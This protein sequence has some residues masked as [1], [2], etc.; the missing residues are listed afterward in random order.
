MSLDGRLR[1]WSGVGYRHLPSFVNVDK[2]LD[3]S[4]A[5]LA[6]N[7]R[8]NVAGEPTLYIAGDVGLAIAEWGCHYEEAR[9]PGLAHDTVERTVYR[10]DLVIERVL[11]LRD[12]QLWAALSLADAPFCF[13]DQGVAR[14]TAHFIRHTSSAQA[15]FVPSA[16]MLDK[17]DR[18]N[19]VLFLEKLPR[20]PTLFIPRVAVEGPFRWR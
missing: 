2:V 7:N 9:V 10:L 20:D 11:D 18:W 14:A 13:L 15:I 17:L 6:P 3:F 19:L 8:W 4:R 1:P 12:P 16:A 5:G